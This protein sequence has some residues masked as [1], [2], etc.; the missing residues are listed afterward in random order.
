[1]D[2][3]PAQ[4]VIDL[5]KHASKIR[6]KV[7]ESK[8]NIMDYTCQVQKFIQ[9]WGDGH[10]LFLVDTSYKVVVASRKVVPYAAI[11]VLIV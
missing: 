7:C 9:E 4:L 6:D 2:A 11:K 3:H 5:Y 8:D 10:I 1:M